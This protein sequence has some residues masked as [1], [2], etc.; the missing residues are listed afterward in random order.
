KKMGKSIHYLLN[1]LQTL[2]HSSSSKSVEASHMF[3]R[4]DSD[5]IATTEQ[6]LDETS[7]LTYPTLLYSR[8]YV[9]VN[10]AE[11]DQRFGFWFFQ[12]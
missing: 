4:T 2:A 12:S 9:M 7:L 1:K 5:S 11:K 10:L 8:D 6:G 3:S